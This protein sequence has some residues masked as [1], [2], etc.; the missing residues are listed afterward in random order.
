LRSRF[1]P[2]NSAK[3]GYGALCPVS[4]GLQTID[5]FF[6][7]AQIQLKPQSLQPHTAFRGI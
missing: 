1:Q 3:H 2:L 4:I 7:Y 5:L 6:A